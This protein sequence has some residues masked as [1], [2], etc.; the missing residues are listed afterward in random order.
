[1]PGSRTDYFLTRLSASLAHVPMAPA[2]LKYVE[3]AAGRVHVFDSANEPGN[4]NTPTD[5]PCIVFTP[6]G[7]NVVA[8]YRR[9]IALLT[10]HFR[11]VCFDM[12]GFGFSLPA[13]NYG[14]GLEQGARAVLA[15][16]DQLGIARATLAF[17]CANGLY[18]IRAAQLAP[19]RIASLMLSQTP[20]LPAMQAWAYR[21]IPRPLRLPV[22]GQFITWLARRKLAQ[23]WHRS[24]LPAQTDARPFQQLTRQSFDAGG[25]FCLAGVVQGLLRETALTDIPAPLAIPCTLIWGEQDRSHRVTPPESLREYLPQLD[26]RRFADCGHFPDLEQPERYVQEIIAHMAKIAADPQP[27][28]CADIVR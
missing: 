12:P 15:V 4:D 8:H 19:A 23:L 14:H 11:V 13:A 22:A 7:P 26:I 9:L 6:D 27:R 2:N 18:A 3:T 21:M 17:S 25:C 10:P 1:M 24:A 16:L 28:P 20:S 5:C